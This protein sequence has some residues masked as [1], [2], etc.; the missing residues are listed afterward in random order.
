MKKKKRKAKKKE[1]PFLEHLEELRWRLW[2]CISAVIVFIFIAFPFTGKILEILTYP[3]TRL[4]NPATFVFLKPT[5]M[6]MLRMEIAIIAGIIAALPIILYQLWQFFA[7]GLYPKERKFIGPVIFIT[8]FCFFLGVGFAY[9]VLIPVILP[10]LFS[11]GTPSIRPMININ[12]YA[13]FVLRLILLTGLVFEL[14]MVSF[15]LTR[16]GLLN[17]NFLRKARKYS[18]L[19]IFIFAAIVTPPDPVSQIVLALPLLLLYEV[20]IW[21]S[22]MVYKKKKSNAL[23][24]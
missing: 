15:F 3:N 12:D 23:R 7:P 21:V 20:S 22:Q 1:M 9:A 4:K 5:G 24:H 18:I 17:P 8:I 6:L 14:P 19:L 11:L 2:K 13:Q 16:L 10:F